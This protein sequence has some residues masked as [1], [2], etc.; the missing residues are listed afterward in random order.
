MAESYLGLEAAG[1]R[2]CRF[3]VVAVES[4]TEPPRVTVY[5]DAFAPAGEGR[6]PVTG[7]RVPVSDA[8]YAVSV[9]RPRL[10]RGSGLKCRRWLPDPAAFVTLGFRSWAGITQW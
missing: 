9:V 8:G 5:P 1:D 10:E 2:V 3:D 6:G 7:V 4:E